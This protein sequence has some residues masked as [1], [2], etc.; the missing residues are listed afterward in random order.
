M[1][2]PGLFDLCRSKTLVTR[3]EFSEPVGPGRRQEAVEWGP[4]STVGVSGTLRKAKSCVQRMP[5]CT[6]SNKT[7][8]RGN[9]QGLQLAE[10]LLQV[11]L[12]VNRFKRIANA[13]LT[14]GL[15]A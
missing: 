10:W 3:L 4:H 9:I 5:M 2:Q 8:S 13:A 14:C 11:V 7:I 1:T 6:T 15:I 12:V